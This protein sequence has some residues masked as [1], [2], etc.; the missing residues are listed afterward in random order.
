VGERGGGMKN[1]ECRMTKGGPEYRFQDGF[2]PSG[3]DGGWI[4]DGF[5]ALLSIAFLL[6]V[7][8][9]TLAAGFCGAD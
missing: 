9:F 3:D 7:P 4:H 2:E 5:S 1:G 6:A 8:R